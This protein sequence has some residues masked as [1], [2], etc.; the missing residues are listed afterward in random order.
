M[1]IVRNLLVGLGVLGGSLLTL[2]VAEGWPLTVS[3]LAGTYRYTYQTGKGWE[4][5]TIELRLDGSYRRIARTASRETYVARGTWS[6]S[7]ADW[8]GFWGRDL[9]L[10]NSR[11]RDKHGRIARE[12]GAAHSDPPGNDLLVVRSL[13]GRV[14]GVEMSY[15]WKRV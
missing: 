3:H 8:L 1:K 7:N 12:A 5:D 2:G 9:T 13:F 14:L 6:L 10:H 15:F 4:T 11:F